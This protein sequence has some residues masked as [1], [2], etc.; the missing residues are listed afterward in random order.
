MNRNEKEGRQM[1]RYL[2]KVSYFGKGVPGLLREGGSGRRK[3]SEQAIEALGGHIEAMYY[4]FGENDAFIIVELPD[5][6][7][8]AAA[9]LIV[10]ASG[11]VKVTYTQLLTPEEVD[12]A[13][14]KGREITT[15]YRAPGL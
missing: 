8:A 7:S 2:I 11:R 1:P 12:K 4:A 15:A 6:I 3:A 10:N 9:S 14:E 5:N 13:A